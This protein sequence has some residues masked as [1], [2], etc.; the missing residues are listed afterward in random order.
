MCSSTPCPTAST[1]WPPGH[2][3]ARGGPDPAWRVPPGA[4]G[5]RPGHPGD[6]ERRGALDRGLEVDRRR[7]GQPSHA[8]AVLPRRRRRHRRPDDGLG[9]AQRA[10]P[11]VR[12]RR[13]GAAHRTPVD[14]AG[15]RA[16]RRRARTRAAPG[17]HRRRQDREPHRGRPGHA[18]RPSRGR[19]GGR[20]VA[21]RGRGG[22]GDRPPD[23]HPPTDRHHCRPGI[24]PDVRGERRPGRLPGRYRRHARQARDARGQ[25]RNPLVRYRRRGVRG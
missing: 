6:A 4:R 19:P 20:H 9:P 23:D 24:D 14:A 2:V 7:R 21:H 3:P 22:P 10:A 8:V 12:G 16:V 1:T 18:R 5:G 11:R 17:R 13:R 15:R 25:D